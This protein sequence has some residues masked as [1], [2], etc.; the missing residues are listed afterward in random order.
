MLRIAILLI[1]TSCAT[2]FGRLG[3]TIAECESRYGLVVERVSAQVKE[4]DP[5]ACV[6]S[7]S[8]VTLIVEFKAGK[9]WKSTYRITGLDETG[10]QK[11]LEAE[12]GEGGWSAP[13]KLV[14]QEV[15][16]SSD[17]ERVAILTPGKRLDDISS[18]VVVTKA[19]SKANRLDYE[20]KLAAIPDEVKR[21]QNAR[22]LQGL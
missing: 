3:E 7:K 22:P 21:R 17:H 2:A 18:F 8:G 4:S 16:Y 1:V 9:A 6:F 5:E 12:G 19:Y 14:N 10:L 11:L 15:R 20:A 13:L